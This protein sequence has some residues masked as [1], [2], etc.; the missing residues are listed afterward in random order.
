LIETPLSSLPT[1][2]SP[3]TP[4][5]PISPNTAKNMVDL[6]WHNPI[7][8]YN[9]AKGLAATIQKWEKGYTIN[10]LT[11][12]NKVQELQKQLDVYWETVPLPTSN[13]P[14]GFIHND[15]SRVLDFIVPS[16][17]GYF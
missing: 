6:H 5:C 7:T 9:V 16:G 11:I 12:A 15:E 3:T 8:I 2:W 17:N 10:C 13:H 14:E 1:I 4:P